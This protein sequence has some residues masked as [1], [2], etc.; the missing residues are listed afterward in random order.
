[1]ITRERLLALTA[2]NQMGGTVLFQPTLPNADEVL[3]EQLIQMVGDEG[4]NGPWTVT[5]SGPGNAAPNGIPTPNLG[6]SPDLFARVFYTGAKG[7]VGFV[8]VDWSHGA[9]ITVFGCQVS[10]Q[11]INFRRIGAPSVG[12]LSAWLSPGARPTGQPNQRTLR[13]NEQAQY[14][15]GNIPAL[16]TATVGIP[17]MARSCRHVA[18]ASATLSRNI[19]VLDAQGNIIHQYTYQNATGRIVPEWGG[20]DTVPL[21]TQ[22][23]AVRIRNNDAVVAMTSAAMIFYLAV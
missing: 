8:D 10:V 21:A 11:A 14:L 13:F 17:Q 2:E 4:D 22:A 23:A 16:A 15:P 12:Q 20:A 5:L 7:G 18:L 6:G 9:Q 3:G 19:E 1:M